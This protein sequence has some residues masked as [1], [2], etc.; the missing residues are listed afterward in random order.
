MGRIVKS[1]G[2]KV[3]GCE[4]DGRENSGARE[5]GDAGADVAGQ[6]KGEAGDGEEGEQ[7]VAIL[8]VPAPGNDDVGDEGGDVEGTDYIHEGCEV[9]DHVEDDSSGGDERIDKNGDTEMRPV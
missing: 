5:I 8:A 9:E 2:E 3:G 7:V 6:K 1:P 4:K